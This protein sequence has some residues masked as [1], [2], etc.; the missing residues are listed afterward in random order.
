VS[1]A[2]TAVVEVETSQEK[3]AQPPSGLDVTGCID[4]ALAAAACDAHALGMR[5]VDAAE[6][7]ALNQHYRGKPGPTNVLAFPAP[8]LPGLPKG[9][10]GYLGDLVVCVPVLE[11]EAAEQGKTLEAH[12]AHL[13]IHGCLHL[14]GYEHDT[15]ADAERMERLETEVMAALGYADPYR[16]RPDGAADD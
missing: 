2:A 14:A 6:S 9:Q 13:L 3:S 8:R 4:V 5:W 16:P 1:A 7:A 11:A 10:T 15:G 12:A